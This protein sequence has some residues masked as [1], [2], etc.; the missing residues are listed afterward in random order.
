LYCLSIFDLYIHIVFEYTLCLT[1]G[2]N[3]DSITVYN[4]PRPFLELRCYMVEISNFTLIFISILFVLSYLYFICLSLFCFSLIWYFLLVFILMW[5]CDY[6]VFL[7]HIKSYQTRIETNIHVD[8]KTL[9]KMF[10]IISIVR[11]L[12]CIHG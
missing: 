7:Y 4:S 6:V 1:V 5:F 9:Y 2:R 3:V 8:A 10:V 11:L 12:C